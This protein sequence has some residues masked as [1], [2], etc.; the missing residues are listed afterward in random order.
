[1]RTDSG[2]ETKIALRLLVTLTGSLVA[3]DRI[4]WT[5][6]V[7]VMGKSERDASKVHTFASRSNSSW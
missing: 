3:A 7:D 4:C 5:Q 6:M 2:K 1:M